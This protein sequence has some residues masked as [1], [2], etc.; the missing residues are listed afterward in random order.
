MPEIKRIREKQ[1]TGSN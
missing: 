1:E